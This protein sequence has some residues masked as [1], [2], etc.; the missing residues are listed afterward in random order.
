[1]IVNDFL[2]A[3][4]AVLARDDPG[5][6]NLTLGGLVQRVWIDGEPFRDPGDLD[7]QGLVIVPV[8]IQYP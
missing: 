3:L 1:M 6:G 8:K 4:D 7:N 5:T 2:D